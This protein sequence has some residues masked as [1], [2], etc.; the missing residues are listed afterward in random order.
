MELILHIGREKTGTTSLQSH[1]KNDFFG[2]KNKTYYFPSDFTKWDSNRAFTALFDNNLRYNFYKQ[3]KI[4]SAEEY[5]VFK[6]KIVE[7]FEK[8]FRNSSKLKIEKWIISSENLSTNLLTIDQLEDLK[9]FIY[10]YFS[11]VKIICFVKDQFADAIS[12]YSQEIKMGGINSWENFLIDVNEA[13]PIWNHNLFAQN[14]ASVFKKK[15]IYFENYFDTKG[16][17]RNIVNYF[18]EKYLT[19]THLKII[20]KNKTS[21]QKLGFL[22]TS[23][24]RV[25]NEKYPRFS[26]IKN[27]RMRL[28][29]YKKI[30][31]FDCGELG[32]VYQ[33]NK[34]PLINKFS[35]S[36]ETFARQYLIERSF[37]IGRDLPTINKNEMT[38]IDMKI[39]KVLSYINDL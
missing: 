22:A 20:E 33:K 2:F 3:L 31:T 14:L 36:N 26:S 34:K 4:E 17:N 37:H 35:N 10:K 24:L 9:N 38:N 32:S 5:G 7:D 13:H 18:Y 23:C 25:I 39:S 30:I 16:N 8:Q 6:N 27:E 29:L 15:D 21:N 11:S 1:L 28:H 19:K 12:R